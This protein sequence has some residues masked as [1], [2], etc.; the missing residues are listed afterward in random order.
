MENLIKETER[1][2]ESAP[3]KEKAKLVKR[4]YKLKMKFFK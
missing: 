4:L 2:L 1:R 3:L